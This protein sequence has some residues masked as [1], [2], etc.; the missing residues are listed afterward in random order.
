MS[1][2]DSQIRWGILSTARIASKVCRA[3]QSAEGAEVVAVASRDAGRAERWAAEHG[4]A[5]DYGSYQRL[6]DDPELEAVYVALPP[7]MHAEWTLRALAGALPFA[8]YL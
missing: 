4:V 8:L 1:E 2:A 5:R 3:I 6:L 7:S